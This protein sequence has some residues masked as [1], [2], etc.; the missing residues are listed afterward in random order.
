MKIIK[1]RLLNVICFFDVI[2]KNK[3]FTY[4]TKKKDK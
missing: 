3:N 1:N 4:T 2:E